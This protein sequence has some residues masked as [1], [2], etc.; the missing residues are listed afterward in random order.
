MPPLLLLPTELQIAI[1]EDLPVADKCSLTTTCKHLR[2]VTYPLLL[3]TIDFAV[4]PETLNNACV[5][6]GKLILILLA[7]PSM[8]KHVRKIQSTDPRRGFR[9]QK[10]SSIPTDA[11]VERF[12][13]FYHQ[14]IIRH[15]NSES[16]E[17]I[18]VS[19]TT[20]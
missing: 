5:D 16:I 20:S 4:T 15:C 2:A 10:P 17:D 18:R 1:I 8:E 11:E 13:H 9:P 12:Q 7:N 6:L 14:E 19:D 3:R